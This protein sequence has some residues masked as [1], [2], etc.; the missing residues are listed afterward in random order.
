[1]YREIVFT[2]CVTSLVPSLAFQPSFVLIKQKR[3]S[4]LSSRALT[5]IAAAIIRA[6]CMYDDYSNIL[7]Y[8][9]INLFRFIQIFSDFVSYLVVSVSKGILVCTK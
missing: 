6:V 5:I 7:Q 4:H 8:I 9:K 2:R 3:W 1:M